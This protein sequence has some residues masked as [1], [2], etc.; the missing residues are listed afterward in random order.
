AGL[1]AIRAVF[2]GALFDLGD[3]GGHADD[4]PGT[5]PHV[6]VVRLFDEVGQH[7]FGDL[8][9]GDDAILHRFNRHDVAGRASEHFLGFAA[10]GFDAAVDFVNRDNG[11]L[12]DHDAFTP[13]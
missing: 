7:L 10:D 4:D 2:D 3:F 12:V 13:G 8:E 11:G 6:P 1:G 9:I 5:H